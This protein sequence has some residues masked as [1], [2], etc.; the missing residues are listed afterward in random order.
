[1]R[2][3][4][5]GAS[6]FIGTAVTRQLL[7]AGHD[8]VL[9]VRHPEAMKHSFPQAEVIAADFTRDDVSGV[10]QPRLQGIDAVVN[11]VGIIQET[12]HQTFDLL[13]DRTPRALFSA[14]AAAGVTKIIQISALGADATA[15]SRYH[16]SKKAADDYLAG[17]NIDWVILQP[18]IVYGPR[19]KSM[20][21]F[22]ALAALP[23]VPLVEDGTQLIQPIFIEDLA[24]AVV[25]LVEPAAPRRIKIAAV[26]PKPLTFRQLIDA[27]RQWLS[28][29]STHYLHMP[30]ILAVFFSRIFGFLGVTAVSGDAIK[31][32]Q[33]GNVADVALFVTHFGFIPRSLTEVLS[34]A[35]ASESELWHARLY[36]LL[37]ILRISLALLWIF[38][39]ITSA[40]IFPA[41]E[42]YA[43]IERIGIDASL[44]PVALYGAAILDIALGIALI[45]NWR[46]I[47]IGSAQIVLMVVYSI[48]IAI[49]LPELWVHPF[50]PVTKNIP[51]IVATLIVMAVAGRRWT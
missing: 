21:L 43:L 51:L 42:S 39:G 48:L 6:G 34:P 20:A 41:T 38:T 25:R 30:L 37:P 19:A 3:L 7:A 4:V 10:W 17:L 12:R 22:K 8:V 26:G 28:L 1:M 15:V 24:A 13:H 44:A 31:M 50:G 27:L 11:C 46:I 29:P 40:F 49:G 9:C 33:R 5:T 36:F 18:S 23:V 32:L 16:L 45:L 47:W 2:I 14:S 35:A